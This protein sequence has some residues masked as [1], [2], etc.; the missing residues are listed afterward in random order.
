MWRTVGVGGRADH[1]LHGT[2]IQQSDFQWRQNGDVV[3]FSV[4]HRQ[5]VRAVKQRFAGGDTNPFSPKSNAS[6]VPSGMT[7][8]HRRAA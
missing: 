4:N 2:A 7:R 1:Q 8:R 5:R 6:T 3:G